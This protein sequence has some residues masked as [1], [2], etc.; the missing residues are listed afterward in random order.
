LPS[1]KSPFDPENINTLM[2][3]KLIYAGLFKKKKKKRK[4]K[5]KGGDENTNKYIHLYTTINP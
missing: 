2:I 3:N 1:L 4:K 5:G